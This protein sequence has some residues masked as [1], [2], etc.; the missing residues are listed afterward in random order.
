VR[1]GINLQ[2]SDGA[3]EQGDRQEGPI[4]VAETAVLRHVFLVYRFA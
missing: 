2:N 4:E 3:Q 1:R